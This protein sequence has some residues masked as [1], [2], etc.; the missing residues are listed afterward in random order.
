MA[1]QLSAC[2]QKRKVG[3]KSTAWKCWLCVRSFRP[4]YLI[5]GTPRPLRQHEGG[6]LNKSPGHALVLWSTSSF[7]W[8]TSW[9]G[10]N[11][12]YVHREQRMYRAEPRSRH[13]VPEQHPLKVVDAPSAKGSEN[14]GDL[15]GG[16]GWPICLKRQL[17][18][19]NF[20]FGGQRQFVPLILRTRTS[21]PPITLIPPVIRQIREQEQ[22]V[23]LMACSGGTNIVSRSCLR[24]LLQPCEPF[25]WDGNS[26]F[27]LTEHYGTP[28]LSC[29]LSHSSL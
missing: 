29:G 18:L 13:V 6:I 4:S 12:A 17:S 11:L 19:P 5:K 9:N 21:F 7:W 14:L 20:F 15:W 25:P 23:L 24:C 2:S 22:K 10:H 8:S 3:F 27:K 1:N 16:R 26:S 28:S